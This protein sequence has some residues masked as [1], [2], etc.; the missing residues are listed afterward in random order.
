MDRERERDR[1]KKEGS[2]LTQGIHLRPR[3]EQSSRQTRRL[4]QK[5]WRQ[6]VCMPF[7]R[8]G[9]IRDVRPDNFAVPAFTSQ[10]RNVVLEGLVVLL[11]Q[12]GLMAFVKP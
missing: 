7:N 3:I 6:E 8:P 12:F 4:C 5:S 2:S 9:S 10:L 11:R 1:D